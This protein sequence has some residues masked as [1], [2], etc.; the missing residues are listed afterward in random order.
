MVYLGRLMLLTGAK[1]L[2]S[3]LVAFNADKDNQRARNVR[4]QAPYFTS[5]GLRVGRRFKGPHRHSPH[6][7]RAFGRTFHCGKASRCSST[8]AS[9]SL[10]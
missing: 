5:S 10:L 6:R 2:Q 7:G 9:Y 1:A 3:F 8:I 4:V